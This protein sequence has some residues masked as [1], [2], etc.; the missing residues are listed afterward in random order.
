MAETAQ[1]PPDGSAA[2]VT[3]ASRGIGRASAAALAA[4]G[5]AV[6]I[7]YRSDHEGAEEAADKIGADGGHA[8]AVPIDVADEDSVDRAFR[9][10]EADLGAVRVLVNNAGYSKDGLAVRYAPAAWDATLDTNLKGAFLCARRA[11]P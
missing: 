3:G 5:L 2:L 11:L 9:R 10:I 6:A 8:A 7:G 1:G 4:S